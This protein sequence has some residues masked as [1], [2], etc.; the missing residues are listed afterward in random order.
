MTIDVTKTGAG[1]ANFTSEPDTYLVLAGGVVANLRSEDLTV[2][3]IAGLQEALDGK[4][5]IDYVPPP[6][7]PESAA[8]KEYV[9]DADAVN[10]AAISA[11]GTRVTAAESQ[12]A[13]NV[14]AI[15]GITPDSIGAIANTQ[16]GVA[17]GVATLDSGGK[18]TAAQLPDTAGDIAAATPVA[19]PGTIAKRDASGRMSAVA[20]T[21]SDHVVTKA[22]METADAAVAAT[23]SALGTTVSGLTAASVGAIPTSQKGAANGVATLGSDGKVTAAQLPAA[24]GSIAL[25]DKGAANGVGTLDANAKQTLSELQDGAAIDVTSS[26]YTLTLAPGPVRAKSGAARVVLPK[27]GSVRKGLIVND[28]G[29]TIEVIADEGIVAAGVKGTSSRP[30]AEYAGIPTGLGTGKRGFTLSWWGYADAVHTEQRVVSGYRDASTAYFG[31]GLIGNKIG[32]K[33]AD[34]AGATLNSVYSSWTPVAGL[35]HFLLAVDLTTSTFLLYID[36]VSQSVASSPTWSNTDIIWGTTKFAVGNV[37]S[38]GSST[39]GWYDDIAQ[40]WFDD[41]FLDIS[42]SAIRAKFY[43]AGSAV[44]LGYN[45]WRP[46]GSPPALFF[47]E[48]TFLKNLA[49]P[50]ETWA[51]VAGRGSFGTTTHAISG[52]SAAAAIIDSSGASVAAVTMANREAA[53]FLGSSDG[54][55]WR[56]TQLG[57]VLSSADRTKIDGIEAGAQVNPAI[58]ADADVDAGTA[59]AAKCI[60]AAALKRGVLAF[61]ADGIGARDI[62]AAMQPE[63][64][65]KSVWGN[66][67]DVSGDAGP[68]SFTALATELN[69]APC[70]QL[71]AQFFNPNASV[72]QTTPTAAGDVNFQS[73]NMQIGD[74]SN[75][76]T[77]MFCGHIN[78]PLA[79]AG[80]KIGMVVEN[81]LGSGQC[82]WMD[83]TALGTTNPMTLPADE[84]AAGIVNVTA[85]GPFY[86]FFTVPAIGKSVSGPLRWGWRYYGGN[87][88]GS[89]VVQGPQSRIISMLG[90]PLVGVTSFNGRSG[91]VVP[92]TGDYTADQITDTAS[93]VLMTAAERTKLAGVVSVGS[94]YA[95]WFSNDPTLTNGGIKGSN[96]AAQN[97]AA[98]QDLIAKMLA[99]PADRKK[100]T[101]KGVDQAVYDFI[102]SLAFGG[103]DV[104]LGSAAAA[105]LTIDFGATRFNLQGTRADYNQLRRLSGGT[106]QTLDSFTAPTAAPYPTNSDIL[107]AARKYKPLGV[108]FDVRGCQNMVVDGAL[109]IAGNGAVGLVAIASSGSAPN[110]AG[111]MGAIFEQIIIQ[112][113]AM[114]L[115]A[116]TAQQTFQETTWSRLSMTGV[117][118]GFVL[119]NNQANLMSISQLT[120]EQAAASY[121][122][123]S[124]VSAGTIRLRGTGP[125]MLAIGASGWTPAPKGIEI[126]Q[127]AS[128]QADLLQVE[129][130]NALGLFSGVNVAGDGALDVGILHQDNGQATQSGTT[131]TMCADDAGHASIVGTVTVGGVAGSS[132]GAGNAAMVGVAAVDASARRVTLAMLGRSGFTMAPI[133]VI[134]DYAAASIGGATS[135]TY[136]ALQTFSGREGQKTRRVSAGA[137]VEVS[138][139]GGGGLVTSITPD[140]TVVGGLLALARLQKRKRYVATATIGAAEE[141][142]VLAPTTSTSYPLTTDVN[143]GYVVI[144]NVGT[145]IASIT[146]GSGHTLD[147]GTI[148][149]P[150]PTSATSPSLVCLYRDP[151]TP[152]LWRRGSK[153]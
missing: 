120:I 111:C 88:T 92:A 150:A 28:S 107:D 53:N 100:L 58:I 8:T 128:L 132:E 153:L 136:E 2:D 57:G 140:F 148:A 68:I 27:T 96:T 70:N 87:G 65:A 127:L 44:N 54:L 133:A 26:P 115:F 142:V 97:Y 20:G 141:V 144:Y 101:F 69:S 125:A 134:P 109:T 50:A 9:D 39:N 78:T 10:A 64:P 138:T 24:G 99:S 1:G 25:T 129:S 85:T 16:R 31:A 130:A 52:T 110:T 66:A 17:G 152:T 71:F 7:G 59:T 3:K 80:T 12:V 103:Y 114:G 83:G 143:A 5:D 41:Q 13:A 98:A 36:G 19:T 117:T 61:A 135:S 77:M 30:T 90:V 43:N 102:G 34:A 93:K 47:N 149:L 121:L 139:G 146:A 89:L 124:E 151:D 46:T 49:A 131:I 116:E 6:I 147:G 45:G 73:G 29:G 32:F 126:G 122:F 75:I 76:K 86:G 14:S 33:N 48:T 119:G 72:T 137:L 113:M 15:S 62:T 94:S 74:A 106:W 105:N 11:L 63:V 79:P 40:I 67:G 82:Y 35:H 38:D 104:G 55:V 108:F 56:Q 123:G 51:A 91:V 37:T 21:A 60:T 42:N 23:V 22:Q 145:A 118:R 112:N 18:V 95:E 81:P 84:V 4:A